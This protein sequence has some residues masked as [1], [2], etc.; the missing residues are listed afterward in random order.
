MRRSSGQKLKHQNDDLF[1]VDLLKQ[2]A[3]KL[4]QSKRLMLYADDA[5]SQKQL[6]VVDDELKSRNTARFTSKS[7]RLLQY[8]ARSSA[9]A[10]AASR[11]RSAAT[12]CIATSS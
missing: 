2:Q 9:S 7:V 10:T 4:Y 8:S 5:T 6:A 3:V 11:P 1:L 12:R